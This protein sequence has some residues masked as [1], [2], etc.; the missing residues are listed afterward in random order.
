MLHLL[1]K[2][3]FV[4][5]FSQVLVPSCS[6]IQKLAQALERLEKIEKAD[7]E[8][9]LMAAHD[10][11]I[12]QYDIPLSIVCS[13]LTHFLY[14]RILERLVDEGWAEEITSHG[15]DYV[16]SLTQ[17]KG[18]KVAR[19][20]TEK[21]TNADVPEKYGTDMITVF[22]MGGDRSPGTRGDANVQRGDRG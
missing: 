14:F 16:R 8:A 15:E 21:G 11:R 5:N 1:R 4:T 18:V 19:P 12:E 17:V 7:R 13:D 20:L 6:H 22:R 2:T 9:V 10:K 3:R